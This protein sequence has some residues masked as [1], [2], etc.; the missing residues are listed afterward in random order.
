[1]FALITWI[2]LFPSAAICYTAVQPV[3]TD[4]TAQK[5]EQRE[6]IERYFDRQI[7]GAD[8][9]RQFAWHRDFSSAAVYDAS[10]APWQERLAAWLG[11]IA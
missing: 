10:V 8:Q 3:D 5:A 2:A 9:V 6:Q 4:I 7:G 1:M 11:G